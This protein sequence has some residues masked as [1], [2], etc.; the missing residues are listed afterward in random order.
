MLSD[1]SS[2]AVCTEG[3]GIACKHA[4]ASS[5]A[6][7]KVAHSSNRRLASAARCFGTDF[8]RCEAKW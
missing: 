8:D 5:L 2:D 4:S 7:F 3:R 1:A 6:V